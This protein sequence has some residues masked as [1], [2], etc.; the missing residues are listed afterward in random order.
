MRKSYTSQ[1]RARFMATVIEGLGDATP[2]TVICRRLGCSTDAITDW[3]AKD[4]DFA[5]AVASARLCGEDTLAMQALRIA[6]EREEDPASRRVMVETRLKLL[7][8][9]NP[10]RYG[11]KVGLTD[12]DG[13]P[14]VVQI[15]KPGD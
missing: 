7:A 9:W 3:Q 5:S 1:E 2:L 11:A 4:P 10:R 8:C 14:L 15:L 6:D 12:G 13:G